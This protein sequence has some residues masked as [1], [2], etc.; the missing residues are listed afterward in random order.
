MIGTLIEK[1]IFT[2]TKPNDTIDVIFVGGYRA[3][4]TKLFLDE[5]MEDP[6]TYRIIDN[7]TGEIIYEK[8]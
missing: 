1:S 5:H 6:E 7:A 3:T 8:E 2:K 4:F